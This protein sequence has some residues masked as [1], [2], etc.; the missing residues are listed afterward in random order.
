[1]LFVLF[2]TCLAVSG[3]EGYTAGSHLALSESCPFDTEGE[4][5]AKSG[6]EHAGS[7]EHKRAVRSTWLAIDLC[8]K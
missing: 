5:F 6:K 4:D 3:R 8:A 7:V 2:H 1:M